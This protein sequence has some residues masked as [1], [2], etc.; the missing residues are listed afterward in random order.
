MRLFMK[1]QFALILFA[2]LAGLLMIDKA[3]AIVVSSKEDYVPWPEVPTDMD[4]GTPVPL[5]YDNV[6][7]IGTAAT[8]V[9]V[10]Y[11]WV[12]TAAHIGYGNITL[13][14]TTYSY[15]N[16]SVHFIE[17]PDI[18]GLTSPTTDLSLFRL[19]E[20][21][22][23]PKLEIAEEEPE[24]MQDIYYVGN[25]FKQTGDMVYWNEGTLSEFW[26]YY[27]SG[28]HEL[29]WGPNN[30][31]SFTS[32]STDTTGIVVLPSGVDMI[33]FKSYFSVANLDSQAVPGD[34]G[35][36]TF[37]QNDEGDWVL[38]GIISCISKPENTPNGTVIQGSATYSVALSYY[39]DQ[40]LD[41]IT[42]VPGDANGDGVVDSSDATILAG[43]WQ[44]YTSRG[45]FA[46]DFNED[47]YVDASDATI[48]AGN[49]QYGT[50]SL[51][52]IIPEPGICAMLL[53]LVPM[54]YWFFWRRH[55]P[56]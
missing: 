55:G 47:G 15:V 3:S 25:G 11:G 4:W 51:N 39:R 24:V 42:P 16:G 21:P 54:G 45:V 20:I 43:N 23:L 49:W 34:S 36:A 32:E 19:A 7:V 9:Y 52:A 46:G 14:G 29:C 44:S 26:G 18:D 12:L 17:N 40:I 41:I 35:G 22:D 2:V 27:L 1:I 31:N 56:Y 28:G 30:V 37:Y 8:G 13:D 50:D 6:G 10:G 5:D 48:L 38:G 33:G 53:G